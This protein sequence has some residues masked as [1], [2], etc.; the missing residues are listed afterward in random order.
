MNIY[1]IILCLRKSDKIK[2]VALTNNE[3]A[4]HSFLIYGLGIYKSFK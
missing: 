1:A 2:K 4:N 3:I